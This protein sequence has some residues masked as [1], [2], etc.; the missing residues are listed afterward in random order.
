MNIGDIVTVGAAVGGAS[1]ALNVKKYLPSKKAVKSF[2]ID[3]RWLLLRIGLIAATF[4]IMPDSSCF[5][6]STKTDNGG[7][8]VISGPLEKFEQLMTG[9]MP[10]AIVSIG[11]AVGG[12]SWALNIENQIV[13]TAMRVVG[14]GSVALA[15]GTFITQSTGIVIP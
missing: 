1:W 8:D 7:I 10:K 14:G 3:N 12:A 4:A 15:A 5:A 13:K 11:A 2:I 6:Q 9:T